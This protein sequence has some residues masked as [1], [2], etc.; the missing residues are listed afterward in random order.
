MESLAAYHPVKFTGEETEKEKDD[1]VRAFQED[2]NHR[3]F[4]GSIKAAGFGLTLTAADT[5]VFAELDWVPG[6]I[7]QAEDRL[8][9]IGQQHPVLVQHIVLNG[10]IDAA[11]VRTI[12]SKQ[13][14]LDMALDKTESI[15]VL[16]TVK[17]PPKDIP[18]VE[19]LSEEQVRAVQQGLR[20]LSSRDLDRAQVLNGVGFNKIDSAFGHALAAVEN[21]SPRQAAAG[22]KLLKKYQRQLPEELSTLIYE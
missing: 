21:L 15:P 18:S 7:T 4:I 12:I 8:H 20:L 6:S 11:L 16:G 13:R 9:R 17:E 22:K 14:V 19:N 10:S 1:A 5:V 2:S 3:V